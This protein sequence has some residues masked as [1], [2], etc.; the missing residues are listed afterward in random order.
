M[1]G[2][3]RPAAQR[4]SQSHFT[5][6]RGKKPQFF[7]Q[8]GN[9]IAK[10]TARQEFRPVAFEMHF[11]DS[12]PIWVWQLGAFLTITQLPRFL[13]SLVGGV[14]VAENY[15]ITDERPKEEP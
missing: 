2:R 6:Y 13:F 15:R 11:R 1:Q 14:W 4:G 5:P 3:G 7:Q 9:E 8:L 10:F 12:D